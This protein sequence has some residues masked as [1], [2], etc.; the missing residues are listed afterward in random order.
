MDQGVSVIDSDLQVVL[1]NRKFLEL[2]ELPTEVCK[3]GMPFE[4][5]I[6]FNAER[7]EYGPGDIGELVKERIEAVRTFEPHQFEHVRPDGT[8][9]VVQRRPLPEGG[10]VTTYTDITERRRTEEKLRESEAKLKS[11]VDNSPLTIVLKDAEGRYSMVNKALCE[12]LGLTEEE[13]IGQTAYDYFPKELVDEYRKHD[14]E[15]LQSGSP[16]EM[17]LPNPVPNGLGPSL[18][19]KFPIVD[20]LGNTTGIGSIATDIS[21]RKR[22]EVMLRRQA[23]VVDQ[24]SDGLIITDTD[25]LIVDW[26]PGAERM[27]G[28]TREEILGRSPTIFHPPEENIWRQAEIEEAFRR[29]RKYAGEMPFVRKDGT[30]GIRETVIVP[31]MTRRKTWWGRSASTT[32]LPIARGRKRRSRC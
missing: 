5:V 4:D 10:L 8:V 7:G 19:V 25:R 26:N 23:L 20:G 6:R 17:E 14:D 31:F 22:A 24:M 27:F 3:P 29:H 15:V 16:V 30:T 1:F 13:L 18:E 9:I 32:T 12:S 28:Y 21:E 11:I 2:F